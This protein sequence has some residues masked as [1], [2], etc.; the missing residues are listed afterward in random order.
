[1]GVGVIKHHALVLLFFIV[2]NSMVWK[3]RHGQLHTKLPNPSEIGSLALRL[4]D[5]YNHSDPQ[6]KNRRSRSRLVASRYIVLGVLSTLLSCGHM[7][8]EEGLEQ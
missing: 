7:S 4:G 6:Q 1:M 8:S 2:C 3:G 5:Q